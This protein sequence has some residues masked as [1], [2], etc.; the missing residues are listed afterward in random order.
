MRLYLFIIGVIKYSLLDILVKG[1]I[2]EL[3]YVSVD[4]D[5]ESVDGLISSHKG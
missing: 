5:K 2:E 1:K 3:L 4:S